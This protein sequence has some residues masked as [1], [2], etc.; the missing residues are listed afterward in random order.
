[1]DAY[2]QSFHCKCLQII[3]SYRDQLNA[4]GVETRKSLPSEFLIPK[5]KEFVSCIYVQQPHI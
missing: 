4:I 5:P 3:V 2:A 1:M